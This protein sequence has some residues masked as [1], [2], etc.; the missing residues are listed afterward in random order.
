MGKKVGIMTGGGD[1]PGLNAVIRAVVRV[2]LE[3]YDWEV[4]GIED[5]FHGLVDLDY[6]APRGNRWLKMEDVRGILEKGGTILGTSN[7]ADPFHYVVTG[8]DGESK[9]IDVSDRVLANYKKVGLDAVV[10]IGGDGSMAIAQRFIE[11]GMNIVGVPKTIDN[12]LG[13][14]DQTFGFDTALNIAT[15]AIDRIRDTADSHDRVMLVEVMGRHAGWIALHSGLA[16]GA[17]VILIPEIPYRLKPIAELI[18]RRRARGKNYSILVVAEGAKPAGGEASIFEKKLGEMPRL[19]G[20]ATKVAAG[21]SELIDADMRVT[22][23]GHVQRGGSPSTFDRV[24]A[25]RYGHMAAEL[26]EAGDYGKMAALRGGQI[27]AV[28]IADA[29]A[30]P[31]NVDPKGQLAETARAVGVSFGE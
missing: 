9:E 30:E 28:P 21:L 29:I 14:T 16:G 31:K 22:V 13:S 2:G 10:S 18:R 24:L 6:A 7:R 15:E 17:D 25:T 23:L 1:C 8:D 27:V 12:D 11:K 3:R 5:A 4:F 26:V 20:A 19:M